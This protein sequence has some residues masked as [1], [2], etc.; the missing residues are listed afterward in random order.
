MKGYVLLS[1]EA[2]VAAVRPCSS[3]GI[4]VAGV[5]VR[6][7][8]RRRYRRLE[9]RRG[10]RAS[11]RSASE[12]LHVPLP[13]RR[14]AGSVPDHR[15][16]SWRSTC[17]S[18]SRNV[19]TVHARRSR[20]ATK[21]SRARMLLLSLDG[22]L[23][24]QLVNF[25]IF[26][27]ILN[28]DLLAPGGRGDPSSGASTSTASVPTTTQYQAR[29]ES[30]AR[31]RPNAM[32]AAARR[33]AERDVVE[34]ARRGVERSRRSSSADYRVQAAAIVA[35][36]HSDGR[37]ANSARRASNEDALV[38]ALARRRCS[39]ARSAAGQTVSP[40]NLRASRAVEPGRRRLR[41]SSPCS[42]GC[43]LQV[44]LSR[45]FVA[46]RTRSN[47]ELAEAERRRDERATTR[48]ICAERGRSGRRATPRRSRRVPRRDAE[49]EHDADRRRGRSEGRR[50]CCAT[51]AASS[52]AARIAARDSLRVELLEQALDARPRRRRARVERRRSNARWSTRSSTI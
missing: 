21:Q 7:G 48:W 39:S 4:I 40:V 17:C 34:S 45:R 9:S 5:A 14:R 13:R 16:R 52:I 47:A 2:L 50:A 24:V 44:H 31:R 30:V 36:A 18:S 27:A 26:L 23:V 22:T 12:H 49:R 25:T 10:D 11:A 42:S 37:G 35:E 41:R 32:R 38:E 46:R 3:F 20:P 51:R 15:A 6:F 33:E 19:P 43:W 29:G 28:V 8:S 1:S